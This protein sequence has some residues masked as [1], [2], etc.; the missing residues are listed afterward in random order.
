MGSNA[1]K[2][3]VVTYSAGTY[4]ASLWHTNTQVQAE[5]A[6]ALPPVKWDGKLQRQNP[7]VRQHSSVLG[8]EEWQD[9]VGENL[10]LLGL[11]PSEGNHLWTAEGPRRD[12][13]QFC[14]QKRQKQ[15]RWGYAST[16]SSL[17]FPRA[18]GSGLPKALPLKP[19]PSWGGIQGCAHDFLLCHLMKQIDLR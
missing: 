10:V 16:V 15:S 9:W 18:R 8:Q 3:C 6:T 11:S 5:F 19:F 13:W 4:Q 17:G 12:A 7:I 1:G 14:Q 2:P